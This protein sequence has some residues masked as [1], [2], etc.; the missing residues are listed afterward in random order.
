MSRIVEAEWIWK[1]GEFIRW[2]DANVHLLSLA[3]QFGS[4]VF[5]GIRCYRTPNGPAVFRLHDHMRRLHDSCRIYRMEQR[6][7]LDELVEAG[8]ATVAR[9]GFDACY[10]RPMVLR[11]YGPAGMNPVGCPIETY[12]P[13]WPWG[14]YLGPDAL[15]GRR[16]CLHLDLAAP[17]AQ[18]LPIVGQGGRPLQQCAAHPHG[19]RGQRLCRSDRARSGRPGQ[20]RQ[21]HE[22]VPGAQRRGDHA[23]AGWHFAARHH[24]RL[25]PDHCSRPGPSYLSQEVPRETLYTADEV[26]F[27]GTAA[28]VTPVRSVDRI[29]IGS[30]RAGPITRQLQ[31]RFLQV[32]HGEAEDRYGWLAHVNSPTGRAGRRCLS[33]IDRRSFFRSAGA[34]GA[35]ALF[36]PSLRGLAAWNAASATE[37]NERLVAKRQHTSDGY[38][39]LVQSTTCPELFIPRDFHIVKLSE[40]HLPSSANPAFM[41]PAAV[42][43]MAAFA[44]PNGNVRLIRNHEIG[45]EATR[46]KPFGKRPY[47]P[48]AGGGTTSLEVRVTGRGSDVSLSVVREFPSLTGTLINCAG[49]RTPWGSWLSC[50]ETT[51][52]PARGY[53]KAHGYVFE[54][55]VSA[56]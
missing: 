35:T 43:G 37:L 9:N 5:E 49:G 21:R 30:G 53:E 27:T 46:A 50:E 32:V 12:I 10:L 22:R 17:G 26:F 28:E 42:D 41:V 3:V 1:D 54:V 2:R 47:D 36:A 18:H 15:E 52:G 38:G 6:W 11:G 55:P 39:E 23:H 20:R 25:D 33:R 4:S 56:T 14:T 31:K 51:N 45:D 13:A 48:K 44:L 40:T 16:G 7:T 34:L 8:K 19:S 29:A 24:A